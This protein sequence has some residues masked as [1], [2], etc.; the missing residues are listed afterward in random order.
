MGRGGGGCLGR[1]GLA[2]PKSPGAGALP[3]RV[4]P[5]GLSPA[6]L[7]HQSSGTGALEVAGAGGTGATGG[8][9]GQEP[10]GGRA[11]APLPPTPEPRCL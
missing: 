5:A 10:R 4:R 7:S 1:R 8:R 11:Q 6:G 9:G 2:S 3:S